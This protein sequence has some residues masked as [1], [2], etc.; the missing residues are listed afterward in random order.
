MRK[1][2]WR[3]KILGMVLCCVLIMQMALPVSADDTWLLVDG[4]LLTEENEAMS[5]EL[6]D[7]K[8]E[9]EDSNAPMPF[10][11]YLYGGVSQITNV[12]NGQVNMYGNTKAATSCDTVKVD[13]YLQYYSN[14]S[15]VHVNN[16]NYTVKNTSYISRSRTVS[17]TKGRYY[18]VKCY[19]AITKNGVKESCTT[20]TDGIKIN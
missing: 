11:T 8:R 16:F 5:D 3:K 17:V 12:G 9:I 13:M 18:R 15:W 7:F 19:H 2:K 14:G 20:V 10:A 6:L 4:S 1:R